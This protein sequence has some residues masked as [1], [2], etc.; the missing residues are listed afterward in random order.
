M[1]SGGQWEGQRLHEEAGAEGMKVKT[2]KVSGSKEKGAH[3]I[4]AVV[5][6]ETRALGRD[7]RGWGR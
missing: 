5:T 1:S 7:G 2:R 4:Q 3:H 6:L